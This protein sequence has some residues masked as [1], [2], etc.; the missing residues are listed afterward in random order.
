MDKEII[1]YNKDVLN[2][3]KRAIAKDLQELYRIFPEKYSESNAMKFLDKALMKL[4]EEY[5]GTDNQY[6]DF[7]VLACLTGD[8]LVALT[9]CDESVVN[10]II[11]S[12]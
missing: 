5:D 4:T 12:E 6:I 1:I 7:W 11:V 2:D 8:L 3:M 10:G 9:F